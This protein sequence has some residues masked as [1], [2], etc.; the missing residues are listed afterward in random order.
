MHRSTMC[1]GRSE[2]RVVGGGTGRSEMAARVC[3]GEGMAKSRSAHSV[4]QKSTPRDHRSA[5]G[6]RVSP[7]ACSGDM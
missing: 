2:R 1:L 7:S 4:S 6:A 5:A 3:E